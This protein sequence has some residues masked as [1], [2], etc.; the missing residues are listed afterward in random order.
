MRR[1][2]AFDIETAKPFPE[3]HNWRSSR[4][5]GIACAAACGQDDPK[6][7]AWYHRSPS[8]ENVRHHL[9]IGGVSLLL[10]SAGAGPVAGVAAPTT[11][12][13]PDLIG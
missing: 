1:Y 3:D 13:R 7:R 9:G 8:G 6:P 10:L 4:P 2:L 5:L 11:G 12:R